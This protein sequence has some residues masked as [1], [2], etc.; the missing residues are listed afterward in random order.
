MAKIKNCRL[1]FHTNDEDKDLNTHV[2]VTVRDEVGRIA[3]RIDSDFNHFDDH[4]DFETSLPIR[5]QSTVAEL[6]AGTVTI[7]IDPNGS[8]TWRFNFDLDL[9][10]EDNS[11]L[12]GGQSG[13]SLNQ[14]NR[15]VTLGLQGLLQP[16]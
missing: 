11:R 3:A 5:H 13:L 15:E 1:R 8:D 2:T 14:N 9:V 10:F 12:G 16:R 7:R 4:T 6:Q